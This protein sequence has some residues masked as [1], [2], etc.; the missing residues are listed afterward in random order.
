MISFGSRR[1]FMTSSLSQQFEITVKKNAI[2]QWS[3]RPAVAAPSLLDRLRDDDNKPRPALYPHCVTGALAL[4]RRWL[5]L[6]LSARW[7]H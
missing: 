7:F 3:R 6:S 4:F 2:C 5:T 1:G